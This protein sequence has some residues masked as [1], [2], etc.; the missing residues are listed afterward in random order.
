MGSMRSS[1]PA[2]G[3]GSLRLPLRLPPD[4]G[5]NLGLL[6]VLGVL[7]AY[8]RST[9]GDPE[10]ALGV[11][12]LAL[13]LALV[14][15]RHA[16]RSLPWVTTLEAG[17]RRVSAALRRESAGMGVD[18]R[19]TPPVP[20]GFPPFLGGAVGLVAAG[21][22]ALSLWP[23]LDLP[24]VRSAVQA[25][26]GLAWLL[27]LGGSWVLFAGGAFYLLFITFA[28]THDEIVRSHEGAG[29]RPRGR[30]RFA[31][32][33]WTAA[34]LGAWF[35]LPPSASL[36][37]HVACLAAAF[38]VLGLP[39]GTD[40]PLLWKGGR[41]DSVV[42]ATSWRAHTLA[43][44][45]LLSLLLADTAL[46][47]RAPAEASPLTSTFAAAFAWTGAAALL[48][49]TP[50][51]VGIALRA[52]SLASGAPS[53]GDRR[54]QIRCRRA[55]VRGLQFLFKRAA[56]RRFRRGSGFWVAPWHWFCLGLTRD[57]DE[58]TVDRGEG[59]F[60]LE[61]IGPAY[62]R[63]FPREA[64]VH[65]GAVMRDLQVDLVF[66][67]DGVGFRRFRRVLRMAFEVHDMLG[68]RGRAEDR[69][70]TGLPGVRV[71]IHD[72][73]M[74]EPFRRTRGGYPEPDYETVGRARI[75][76]VF[77][78]RGESEETVDA[79]RDRRGAPVFS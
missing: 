45:A 9:A 73:T 53:P 74:E 42:S 35:L 11:A 17:F 19:G 6:L 38:L 18:L 29:P 72:F 49:W 16:R 75:L 71:L 24:A 3:L 61:T 13:L 15:R 58:R 43:G 70:F 30:E 39:G 23:S 69:H 67:E 34:L 12:A 20:R 5:F 47:L 65:A 4:L 76:H 44:T 54:G 14:R 26:S 77:R 36:A 63:V 2:I 56:G 78:D 7:E 25:V 62:H 28:L 55:L 60:F 52:R 22:V 32:A 66:V 79:P 8:G 46:L 51:A 37:V 64:L 68:S 50:I 41:T 33:G 21:A 59:T 1:R 40:V 57:E 27:L 48:C 10:D 31:L